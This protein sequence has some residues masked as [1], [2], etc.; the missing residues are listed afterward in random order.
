MSTLV[1]RDSGPHFCEKDSSAYGTYTEGGR[2]REK[3]VFPRLT[4]DL[5]WQEGHLC[6]DDRGTERERGYLHRPAYCYS[7]EMGKLK[8][9]LRTRQKLL[10][11]I[12][13]FKKSTK[14]IQRRAFFTLL[15]CETGPHFSTFFPWKQFLTRAENSVRSLCVCARAR[16]K[17]SWRNIWRM[18]AKGKKGRKNI[19]ECLCLFSKGKNAQ[20]RW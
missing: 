4:F 9:I 8:R 6:S 3:T 12:L 16:Q 17:C 1:A 11:H 18:S 20:R 13:H 19:A 2:K 7:L 15:F 10:L 5:S 14:N